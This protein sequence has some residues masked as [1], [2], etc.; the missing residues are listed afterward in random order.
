MCFLLVMSYFV[1][2][3]EGSFT[4]RQRALRINVSHLRIP[5]LLSLLTRKIWL[6]EARFVDTGSI[7]QHFV[8]PK[9]SSFV[10][11]LSEN[12]ARKG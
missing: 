8:D 12:G 11:I 9:S 4:D 7:H 2:S 10:A 6:G 1:Y 3:L 5:S